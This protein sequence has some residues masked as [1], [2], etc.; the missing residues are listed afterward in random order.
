VR[1]AA[2]FRNDETEWPNTFSAN[3]QPLSHAALETEMHWK[4]RGPEK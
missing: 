4:V 2:I 1:C 3:S